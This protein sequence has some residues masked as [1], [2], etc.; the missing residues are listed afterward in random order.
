[1]T[2]KDIDAD[3]HAAFPAV[4]E[5][6]YAANTAETTFVAME[7]FL[8]F[9]HPQVAN[10]AVVFSEDCAAADADVAVMHVMR[11]SQDGQE[12]SGRNALASNTH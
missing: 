5:G 6:L 3:T 1:M 12:W 11:K 7:R 4:S 9:G 2:V 8:G 10:I